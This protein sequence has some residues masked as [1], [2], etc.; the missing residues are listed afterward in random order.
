MGTA[1]REDGDGGESGWRSSEL[2]GQVQVQVLCW[3]ARVQS[4]GS[5]DKFAVETL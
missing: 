5:R 3:A 4:E 2:P 1:E